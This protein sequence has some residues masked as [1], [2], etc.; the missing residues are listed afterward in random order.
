M[1]PYQFQCQ[2]YSPHPQNLHKVFKMGTS[3]YLTAPR[4]STHLA[5]TKFDAAL[6]RHSSA[7]LK[8]WLH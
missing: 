8:F 7:R 3:F 4:Q 1:P 2:Q 6:T 5:W